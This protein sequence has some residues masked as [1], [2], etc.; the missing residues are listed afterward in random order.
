MLNI[1]AQYKNFSNYNKNYN[2]YSYNTGFHK[3]IIK[4]EKNVNN[5][6][7]ITALVC[8]GYHNKI[9][10]LKQQKR[11]LTAPGTRNLK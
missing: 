6:Q 1:N 4:D 7:K 10:W 11:A 2:K 9:S 8:S 3:K 5:V